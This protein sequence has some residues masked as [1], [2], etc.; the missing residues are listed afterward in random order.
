MGAPISYF[1]ARDVMDEDFTAIEKAVSQRKLHPG[2]Q[3]PEKELK[4]I[5]QYSTAGYIMTICTL[6]TIILIALSAAGVVSGGTIFMALGITGLAA[7]V[8]TLF[9]GACAAGFGRRRLAHDPFQQAEAQAAQ[10]TPTTASVFNSASP[11]FRRLIETLA[12][13]E[14]TANTFVILNELYVW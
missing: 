13:Q 9:A 1:V 6:I 8:I 11:P 3:I 12:K 14:A 4:L 5:K 10:L 7:I 2:H